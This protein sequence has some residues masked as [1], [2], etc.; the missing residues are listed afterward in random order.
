MPQAALIC[1]PHVEALGRFAHRTLPLG[2]GN[3]RG[4]RD[5]RSFGNLV[6]HRKN[7]GEIAV[8]S[9]GPNVVA[10]QRLDQLGSDTE[11]IARL[12]YAAF[13][14][15]AHTKIASDLF[16]VDGTALV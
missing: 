9:L 16:N 8:V 6:L 10:G 4:D 15:I 1:G 14:D 12:A 13:E 11:S 5:S 2:I 3:G 7:I